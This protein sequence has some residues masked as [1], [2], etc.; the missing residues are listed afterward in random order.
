MG[1]NAILYHKSIVLEGLIQDCYSICR[2]E[3]RWCDKWIYY[4]DFHD[5]CLDTDG[6]FRSWY[7]VGFQLAKLE[8]DL[9][10]NSLPDSAAYRSHD[11]MYL[12]KGRAPRISEPQKDF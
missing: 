10:N 11:T 7:V 9:S 6:K 2:I 8:L 4:G 1:D 5:L 12:Q 3:K